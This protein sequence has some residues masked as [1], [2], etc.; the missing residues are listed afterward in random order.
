[1]VPTQTSFKGITTLFNAMLGFPGDTEVCCNVWQKPAP[2]YSAW[3]TDDVAG[4]G[5]TFGM[6]EF[7]FKSDTEFELNIYSAVN[8]SV[9]FN[10]PSVT[11]A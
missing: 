6:G 10:I 8:R 7:I 4:D 2:A 1:M 5:G 11:F 9:I 3:R